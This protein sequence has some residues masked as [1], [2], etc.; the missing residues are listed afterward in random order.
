MIQSS[1]IENVKIKLP[2]GGPITRPNLVNFD[3]VFGFKD[4]RDYNR[5]R[6]IK[7]NIPVNPRN[8]KR[9]KRGRSRKLD[10]DIYKCRYTVERFF[11]WIEGYKKISKRYERLENSYFGLVTLACS[12]MPGRIL[13]CALKENT[14][15]MSYVTSLEDRINGVNG[16]R[17]RVHYYPRNCVQ[18]L[19]TPGTCEGRLGYLGPPAISPWPPQAPWRGLGIRRING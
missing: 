19:Q 10:K 17:T 11:S 14:G 2:V 8:I 5:R 6:G 12:L 7:S 18:K 9:K 13:G 3:A 1:I 4:I 16:Y 15:I